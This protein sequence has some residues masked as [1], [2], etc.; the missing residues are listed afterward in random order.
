MRKSIVSFIVFL[1]VIVVCRHLVDDT[2]RDD[3]ITV[4]ENTMREL[5]SQVERLT[6]MPVDSPM[7]AVVQSRT[8]PMSP[9]R[10]VRTKNVEAEEPATGEEK[11]QKFS[12][13]VLLDLN[14][15]DSL[16]LRCVPGIAEK[17]ASM[18]IRY[19][20]RL[21]GFYDPSQLAELLTW[22]SAQQHLDE[23]CEEWFVA[24]TTKIRPL[25]VNSA[26]FKEL[27]RHPY[28]SFDQTK[29]LVNYR[30]RHRGIPSIM[31]LRMLE[32]FSESDIARLTPY[33]SFEK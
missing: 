16:T 1:S 4:I 14:S 10:Q 30:E 20:E 21:G 26:S 22:E 12:N 5:Q 9:V 28:L 24:D 2:K 29:A 6:V 13:P 8:K 19:R 18:I 3:R 11:P 27:L 15:V 31:A 33:L 23:W 32:D 25:N 7:P 17:S